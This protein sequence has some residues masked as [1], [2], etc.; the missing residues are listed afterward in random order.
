M[1][2][3]NKFGTPKFVLDKYN[4][5][6]SAIKYWYVNPVKEKALI[7]AKAENKALPAELKEV[8]YSE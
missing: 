8:H 2:Y 3:W 7:T 6:R 5:E 4:D 1:L